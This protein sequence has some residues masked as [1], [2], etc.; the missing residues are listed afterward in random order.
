ML[1]NGLK[2]EQCCQIADVPFKSVSSYRWQYSLFWFHSIKETFQIMYP[3][4]RVLDMIQRIH[5]HCGSLGSII[6]FLTIVKKCS[7]SK[8]KVL[9][10]TLGTWRRCYTGRFTTTIFSATHSCNVG[11]MLWPFETMSQQCCNAV[12]C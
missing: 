11:L 12:V 8:R 2:D 4:Y 10:I 1:K 5:L 7:I 6:R 9:L 3:K